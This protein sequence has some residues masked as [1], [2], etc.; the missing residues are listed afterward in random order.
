MDTM[1]MDLEDEAST[2]NNRHQYARTR[3]STN[4]PTSTN[5]AIAGSSPSQ[6]GFAECFGTGLK[7]AVLQ[8]LSSPS[9]V[10]AG[11]NT[12]GDPGVSKS[13]LPERLTWCGGNDTPQAQAASAAASA[14]AAGKAKSRK[15]CGGC[16][17]GSVIGRW[18]EVVPS[19][20]SQDR[21]NKSL[22]SGKPCGSCGGYVGV[23]RESESRLQDWNKTSTTTF[24]TPSAP[25]RTIK[26][27]HTIM[28][29]NNKGI[30]KGAVPQEA[31]LLCV[32][33][34]GDQAREARAKQR[35]RGREEEVSEPSTP[36]SSADSRLVGR[37]RGND[38]ITPMPRL[39][40]GQS[41]HD[42][43]GDGSATQTST[44]PS[45]GS[46]RGGGG[47]RGAGGMTAM[48]VETRSDPSS[49][50]V[51]KRRKS[52]QSHGDGSL[53]K[54]RAVIDTWY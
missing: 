47:G 6:E 7:P 8:T 19:G 39:S 29:D 50:P 52:D 21:A 10:G 1:E 12:C 41:G 28:Y 43:D 35:K 33:E 30:D 4:A 37:R 22:S 13:R 2:D 51:S 14:S 26:G 27:G 25:E 48:P 3:L 36:L 38:L 9:P 34:D 5:I 16:D 46:V 49:D 17:C 31:R 45:S 24:T 23:G 20:Q 53:L 44:R 40:W 15:Q 32:A 11:S 42:S 18:G 54:V